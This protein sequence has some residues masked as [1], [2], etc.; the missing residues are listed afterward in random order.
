MDWPFGGESLALHSG[1]QIGAELSQ[2][3]RQTDGRAGGSAG[4]EWA[5]RV[6]FIRSEAAS[7]LSPREALEQFQ[8]S[9]IR[10]PARHLQP[11][12]VQR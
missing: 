4:D 1:P 6:Q 12:R 5:S 7:E 3:D 2:S 8:A 9:P 10:Q 11:A